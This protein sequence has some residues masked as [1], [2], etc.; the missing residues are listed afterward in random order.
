MLNAALQPLKVFK[1][2]NAVLQTELGTNAFGKLTQNALGKFDIAGKKLFGVSKWQ[3]LNPKVLGAYNV[4]RNALIAGGLS[5]YTD[6]LT[7]GFAVGFGLSEFNSEYLRQYDPE[8]Y[9]NT[10]HGG[11][12]VGQFFDA[13]GSG[14]DGAVRAGLTE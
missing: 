8:A 7:T 12:A 10:W 13:I 2:P 9:V 14:I 6:E 4:G 3:T 11:S 1:S 5:N